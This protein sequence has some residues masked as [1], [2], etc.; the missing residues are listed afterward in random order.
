MVAGGLERPDLAIAQTAKQNRP[1]RE[2]TEYAYRSD[3]GSS[4]SVGSVGQEP[5]PAAKPYAATSGPVGA[6][7]WTSTDREY[8]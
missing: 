7:H 5:A 3:L 8:A 1:L 6:F 2:P 4:R